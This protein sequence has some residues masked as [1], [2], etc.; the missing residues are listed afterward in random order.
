MS[1]RVEAHTAPIHLNHTLI[2][3]VSGCGVQARGQ[4]ESGLLPVVG[5]L[6]T[7]RDSICFVCG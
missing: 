2:S 1:C 5:R 6:K 4:G 7:A 3:K